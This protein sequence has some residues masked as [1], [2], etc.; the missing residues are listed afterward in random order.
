MDL[1]AF[2]QCRDHDVTLRVFNIKKT[3]ALLRIILGEN[4]GTTVAR[5]FS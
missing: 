1:A 5:Q 2:C 3:G 4:E